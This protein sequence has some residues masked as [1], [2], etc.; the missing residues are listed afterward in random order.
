MSRTTIQRQHAA[1]SMWWL[2]FGSWVL[3][4]VATLGAL[5]IGE[6]VGQEPCILC[7]YQRICM[8][9]LAAILFVAALRGDAA[10]WRYAMPLSVVGALLSAYHMAELAGI[11][12]VALTPCTA[13]GPSCSGSS[14]MI[15]GLVPIPLLA[16]T[17][18]AAITILLALSRRGERS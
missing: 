10:V 16:F 11:I 15:L 9:P 5:F 6:V 8:F 12:P 14:M 13:T 7:W 17:T 2:L 1:A 3:A 18:F 4:L